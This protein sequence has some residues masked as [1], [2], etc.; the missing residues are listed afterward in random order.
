MKQTEIQELTQELKKRW[1]SNYQ[2]QKFLKSGSGDRIGRFIREY[3]EKGLVDGFEYIERPA[4]E[5]CKHRKEFKL[6]QLHR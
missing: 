6:E 5:D 4:P 2:M 3:A 1:M